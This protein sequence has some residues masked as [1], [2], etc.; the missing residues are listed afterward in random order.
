[1]RHFIAKLLFIFV[2]GLPVVSQASE[3]RLLIDMLHEN[4]MVSEEQYTRLLAELEQ[5]QQQSAK[6]K[7]EIAE[8]LE[9]ATQPPEVEVTTKG[10][11]GSEPQM[12]NLRPVCVAA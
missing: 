8:K 12:V 2:L 3:L 10:G 1:M 6:E 5:N 11:Y 9:L 4:G 7:L